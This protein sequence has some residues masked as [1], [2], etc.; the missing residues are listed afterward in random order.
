MIKP[1]V[2]R[3]VWY[4]PS[5]GDNVTTNDAVQPLA[6]L[7]AYVWNDTIVNL[8]VFDH[9]GKAF[10]KTSVLLRDDPLSDCASWMP[11]QLGQAAKTEAAE[12]KTAIGPGDVS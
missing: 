3:V 8:A 9:N 1:T 2:G 11:Y 10:N 5:G 7:I 6:A 12:A 4:W